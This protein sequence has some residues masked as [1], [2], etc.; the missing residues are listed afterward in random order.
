[1]ETSTLPIQ[2]LLQQ[3]CLVRVI[4]VRNDRGRNELGR[5]KLTQLRMSK[6]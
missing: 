2:L 3:S 1:M 4:H 6:L 5:S